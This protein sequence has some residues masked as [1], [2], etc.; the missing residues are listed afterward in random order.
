[1]FDKHQQI[2]AEA[3]L[4]LQLLMFVA[5]LPLLFSI[6]LI[7]MILIFMRFP[8]VTFSK[9]SY[10]IIKS[11]YLKHKI[12]MRSNEAFLYSTQ[13]KNC[14]LMFI[15]NFQ[16][17]RTILIFLNNFPCFR[18]STMVAVKAA[19]VA[20]PGVLTILA[21]LFLFTWTRFVGGCDVA[22]ILF[23]CICY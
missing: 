17:W 13:M 11:E 8:L 10:Q 4:L 1:M 22:N 14:V 15:F 2:V 18:D 19:L 21:I 16:V 6:K 12:I 23:C 20:V 3:C 5:T 9:N 7:V